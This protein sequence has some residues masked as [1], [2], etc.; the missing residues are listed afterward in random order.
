MGPPERVVDIPEPSVKRTLSTKS[1]QDLFGDSP[2]GPSPEPLDA[3]RGPKD[4]GADTQQGGS[5]PATKD[6]DKRKPQKTKMTPKKGKLT[7]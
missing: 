3:G 6:K 5:K 4:P 1:S 2:E 7:W